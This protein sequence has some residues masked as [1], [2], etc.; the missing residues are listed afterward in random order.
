SRDPAYLVSPA[1]ADCACRR[2]ALSAE[3]REGPVKAASRRQEAGRQEAC[4]KEG[5]EEAQAVACADE[6]RGACRAGAAGAPH[7]A[8]LRRLRRTEANGAAAAREPHRLGLQ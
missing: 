2:A 6:R 5:L 1:P 7:E 3:H 8:R 4:V